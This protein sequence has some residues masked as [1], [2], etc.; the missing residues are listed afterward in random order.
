MSD[1]S[2]SGTEKTGSPKKR[3]SPVRNVIG[4]VVLI[5]VLVAGWM[6]YSAKSGY[7]ATVTALNERIKDEEKG[8][9]SVQET[10][11]L[12][13]KAPD[14][15]GEDIKENNQ[16][17]TKKT[18]TWPGLLKSYTLTAFYTKGSQPGLHHFEPEGTK[19]TPEPTPVP[20]PTA[21]TTPSA[22]TPTEPLPAKT[23]TD[24]APAKTTTEPGPAKTVTD[25]APAKTTTEPVVPAKTTTEPVPAKTTTAPVPAKTPK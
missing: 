10:E 24:R 16:S 8:L 23:V 19:Y 22:K 13:G 6:Q 15:P 5:A 11:I 4:V 21:I 2:S 9:M 3:V 17:F 25:R 1:L 12:L 20:N 7:N 18:Y 14:G